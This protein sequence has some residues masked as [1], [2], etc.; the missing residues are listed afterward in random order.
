MGAL[1]EGSWASRVSAGVGYSGGAWALEYDRGCDGI[2]HGGLGTVFEE[3]EDWVEEGCLGARP[4]R[5]RASPGGSMDDGWELVFNGIRNGVLGMGGWVGRCRVL[6]EG[7]GIMMAWH[8]T[9]LI[10]IWLAFLLYFTCF[11][12]GK[13]YGRDMEGKWNGMEFVD[14]ERINRD[15]K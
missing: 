6:F 5:A 7:I 4:V 9:L 8:Y 2:F 13:G 15:R 3:G 1:E 10:H 14:L 11:A 12:L